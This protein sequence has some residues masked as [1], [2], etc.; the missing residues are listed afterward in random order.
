MVQERI[1]MFIKRLRV[2]LT[3]EVMIGD[4][5]LATYFE[6]LNKAMRVEIMLDCMDK[7]RDS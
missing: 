2:D 1:K 4:H 3:I 6:A 7:E 5:V